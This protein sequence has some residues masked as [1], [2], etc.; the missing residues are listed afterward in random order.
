MLSYDKRSGIV[1]AAGQNGRKI[2]AAVGD[3]RFSVVDD[4]LATKY[5]EAIDNLDIC[6][7][8]SLDDIPDEPN[9]IVTID[10]TEPDDHEIGETRTL[11]V[12]DEIEFYWQDED[13]YYPGTVVSICEQYGMHSIHIHDEEKENLGMVNELWRALKANQATIADLFTTDK[14]ALE[15]YF[16]VFANKEFMLHQAERLP[17]HSVWNAYEDEE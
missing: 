1:S 4:E 13:K 5:Q 12:G 2:N 16:I 7:E 11:N 17:P 6:I 8:N 14:E 10:L 9:D 15:I 3:V